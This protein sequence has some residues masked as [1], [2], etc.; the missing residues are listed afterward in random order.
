MLQDGFDNTA[1]SICLG[2]FEM[3]EEVRRMP[4]RHT[5][6]SDCIATWMKVKHSCPL[7]VAPITVENTAGDTAASP[8]ETLGSPDEVA[9]AERSPELRRSQARS[10]RRSRT[11]T[12]PGGAA[13]ANRGRAVRADSTVQ[14][15][16]ARRAAP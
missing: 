15:V 8:S 11:T 1:C 2:E 6:H 10:P 5:F 13:A 16:G 4:C 3:D 12:G 9:P 14:T 7:C